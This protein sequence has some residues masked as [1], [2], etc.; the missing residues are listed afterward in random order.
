VGEFVSPYD[1]DWPRSW[2][3]YR[4]G[5]LLV[6][7]RTLITW[8]LAVRYCPVEFKGGTSIEYWLMG[9]VTAV[10]FFASIVVHELAHSWV[11]LRFKVPVSRTTL[12]IFGGDPK[13]LLS[14]LYVVGLGIL[15]RKVFMNAYT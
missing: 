15:F 2:N 4:F 3:T 7:D 11:A 14:G 1:S 12:F 8:M 13:L 10:Q 6:L 5:L 9:A